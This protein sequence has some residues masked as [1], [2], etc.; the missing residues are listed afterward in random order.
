[1]S[2]FQTAIATQPAAT[3]AVVAKPRVSADAF[4]NLTARLKKADAVVP[5]IVPVLHAPVTAAPAQI[6]E[7]HSHA[8]IIAA[9]V[10]VTEPISAP[11]ELSVT[12]ETIAPL[13]LAPVV[14]AIAPAEMAVVVEAIAPAE[15]AVVAE[16][17]APAEMAVV[18]EAIASVEMTVVA[19]AITPAQTVVVAET[20]A[21]AKM[22]APME[23]VPAFESIAPVA[24]APIDKVLEPLELASDAEVVAPLELPSVEPPAVVGEEVLLEALPEA[25]VVVEPQPQK[26]PD[27][28]E[29]VPMQEAVL[30]PPPVAAQVQQPAVQIPLQRHTPFKENFTYVPQPGEKNSASEI[31]EIDEA[32]KEEVAQRAIE[33][34]LENIWRL[35]L[36]KPTNDDRT[37]YL[38]EAA[39]IHEGDEE[40]NK[41]DFEHD[42]SRIEPASPIVSTPVELVFDIQ[43]PPLE[44]KATHVLPQ[45]AEGQDLAELTRSLL[46][47]MAAG[48]ASGLPQ[49]RALA[50]DTLLRLVPRLDL[51]PMIM[52]A[53]R[54]AMMDA[55]PNLLVSRLIRD[56][57]VEI[58][59]PLLEDCSHIT[60]KD[61]EQI[62]EEGESDKLRMIG[63]RRKLSRPISDALIKSGDPSVVLTLVRNMEAEIS[64]NGFESL[65]VLCE[66][67]PELLAPLA[68]RQ[69]LAAPFAFEMFW[70]APAQLRRFILSRFLTD[71]ET[72]T[73]ILKITKLANSEADDEAEPMSQFVLLEALERA[74]RGHTEVAAEELSNVMQVSSATVARILGD[75][76]GEALIVM[77]K[78]A[79]Y[80][81]SSL[82]GLLKRLQDA[83]MPLISRE[84]DITELQSMFETLSFNKARI[85]LTYWDWSQSKTGP[86]APVH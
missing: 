35:M 25:E 64:H 15:M 52:V 70:L 12:V 9:P 80:P 5:S 40:W 20:M 78:T 46:D 73:K 75:L 63:R 39:E 6:V 48:N 57:R 65:L 10:I 55:P 16:V 8:P 79:G 58:A 13:G 61:L 56:P 28:P 49:E 85:L 17:S 71:S 59:G 19:E 76:Q 23:L 54:L 7:L 38:R 82:P 74:A 29:F 2:E 3:A 14:E 4:R 18:A 41:P 11:A 77:L 53:Q 67:H 86:Y 21:P 36:A 32:V 83:E 50:A 44:V 33:L 69:D 24:L 22:A 45:V 31:V 42:L 84:R 1:M 43:S 66:N 60:D 26:F 47:M 62:V 34:E 81:R 30:A 68:T 72:L 51:K 37:T 27:L